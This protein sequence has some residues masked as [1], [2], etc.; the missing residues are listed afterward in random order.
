MKALYIF[1]PDTDLALANNDPN[2]MPPKSARKLADDLSLLPIWYASEG[3]EILISSW[4][5]KL[6][7][8]ELKKWF[9][10]PVSLIQLS[11]VINVSR[12]ELKP[13]GW[14]KAL[15]NRFTKI[16]N[17]HIE[18][19]GCDDVEA[20][21]MLSSREWMSKLLSQI[22]PHP[23][24]CGESFVLKSSAD[25]ENINTK[26]S[27]FL[28][29]APYSGSGRGLKWCRS[30][31]DGAA[32]KWFNRTVRQQGLAIAEPIYNRVLDF[33]MEFEILDKNTISFIGFSSFRT[34]NNGVYQGNKFVHDTD[35]LHF[36]DG[37]YFEEGFIESVKMQLQSLLLK[38]YGA[39]YQGVLGVDMMVCKS[40]NELVY[41]LHPCVE[42]NLRMNMGV[43]AHDFYH[44]YVNEKS[45]GEFGVDFYRYE[46]EVLSKHIDYQKKYPLVVQEGKIIS[47]YLSLSAITSQ[48]LCH[49]WVIVE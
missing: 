39:T 10:L 37:T 22:Q 24:L 33:A 28:L 17:P 16:N 11:E 18:M 38:T 13:W 35:F 25:L 40:D 27:R 15:V 19:Y 49:A 48:T 23:Q 41:L 14:N 3:S 29:K 36:L 5:E 12:C 2:F 21:R 6:Y 30:G 7:F 43:L 26:L 47:G 32:I 20:I 44:R 9:D 4:D 34:D 1:N 42:V 31:L 45:S 8:G 46:G